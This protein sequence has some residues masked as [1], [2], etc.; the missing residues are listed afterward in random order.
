MEIGSDKRNTE[1]Q[2]LPL[3]PLFY[4]CGTV[5]LSPCHLVT[6]SSPHPRLVRS[7]S[8]L[9]SQVP[10]LRFLQHHSPDAG[11]NAAVRRSASG[12]DGTIDAV[13]QSSATAAHGLLRRRRS[14]VA[15]DR[16]DA[17]SAHWIAQADR[18]FAVR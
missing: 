15:A 17:P 11:T 12:R 4:D 14:D 9:L 2:S 1:L 10:L 18:F 3:G 16:R 7:H 6:L 8:V 13:A 5:T